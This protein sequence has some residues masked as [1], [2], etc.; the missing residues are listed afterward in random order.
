MRRFRGFVAVTVAL[1]L[2]LVW[3][4]GDAAPLLAKRGFEP[5]VGRIGDPGGIR[6]I[7]NRAR[8]RARHRVDFWDEAEDEYRVKNVL[9][10]GAGIDASTP[11]RACVHCRGRFPAG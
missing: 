8:H 2:A 11:I 4:G 10:V 9:R 1:T 7:D 3:L 5:G 6:S